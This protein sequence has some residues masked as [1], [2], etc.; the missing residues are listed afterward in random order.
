MSHTSSLERS[1]RVSCRF[2]EV[3]GVA[4]APAACKRKGRK[5]RSGQ[6]NGNESLQRSCKRA[7]PEDATPWRISRKSRSAQANRWPLTA[8]IPFY[9][10]DTHH[11]LGIVLTWQSAADTAFRPGR[12]LILR[13]VLVSNRARAAST[14]LH[15][16]SAEVFAKCKPVGADEGARLSA[17]ARSFMRHTEKAPRNFFSVIWY[18]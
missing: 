18:R 5:I 17:L 3:P 11:V 1:T 13:I 12:F 4:L 7:L 16:M 8:T 15:V 14:R 6:E 9:A 2:K 10:S